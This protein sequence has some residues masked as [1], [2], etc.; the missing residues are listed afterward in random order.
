MFTVSC[1]YRNILIC[2]QRIMTAQKRCWLLTE[3]GGGL[4]EAVKATDMS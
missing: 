1:G 4:G 3:S 2:I